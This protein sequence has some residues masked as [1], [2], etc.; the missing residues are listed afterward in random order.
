MRVGLRNTPLFKAI[1][2]KS[3]RFVLEQH[4]SSNPPQ[5]SACPHERHQ[6]FANRRLAHLPAG[7]GELVT[8]GLLVGLCFNLCGGLGIAPRLGDSLR[9]G[10]GLRLTVGV[11]LSPSLCLGVAVGLFGI[12]LFLFSSIPR[13]RRLWG[14][15]ADVLCP[16]VVFGVSQHDGLRPW[17]LGS[18]YLDTRWPNADTGASVFLLRL[19]SWGPVLLTY[20]PFKFLLPSLVQLLFVVLKFTFCHSTSPSRLV[21]YVSP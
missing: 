14:E 13:G 11:N 2:L 1:L 7:V 18:G 15:F 17:T 5:R 6:R 21:S 16:V 12:G 19:G 9:L 4:S 20:Q 10:I 3:R 8:I